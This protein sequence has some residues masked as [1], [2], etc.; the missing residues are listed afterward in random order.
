MLSRRDFLKLTGTALLASVFG[1]FEL[2]NADSTQPLPLPISYGSRLFP[3]IA[4]T[5]DDCW[6]PEVLAQLI[7][8]L[9]PYPEFHFTFFAVGDAIL[10]DEAIR[11]GIWKQLCEKGHEIG[12]HTF[13]HVDPI[14]M[15]SDNLIDDFDQ[16][17]NTLQQILGFK[18]PVHFARPPYDD[19]TPSFQKLCFERGLVPVLYSIGYE[20]PDT[21]E[22]LN[23]AARTR[24]GDIVQMHTYED[25]ANNRLDVSITAK[26]VPYL[27]EQGYK[28]VTMTE[29]YDDVLREQNSSDGCNIG[30]G[31]SLSRSC[32]E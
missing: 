15:S 11:P 2:A 27:A 1:N 32:L 13:H 7:D 24:N 9:T 4:I 18:P 16:W 30:T 14:V 5:F 28:L 3:H 23:N 19:I 8:I 31:E 12:Y 20:A 17:L 6:H 21:E 22:G 26:V 29:L 10:I 25:P